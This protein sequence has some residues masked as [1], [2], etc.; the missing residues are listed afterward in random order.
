M[1][2]TINMRLFYSEA[3]AGHNPRMWMENG[4]LVEYLECPVRAYAIRDAVLASRLGTF[5]RPFEDPD[6]LIAGTHSLNKITFLRGN[7][8]E[9]L[10]TRES[11]PDLVLESDEAL[12]LSPGSYEAAR[13]A[14]SCALSGAYALVE[15][16]EV[17]V[18][19]LC[20][21]PGHHATGGKQGAIAFSIMP[22]SLHNACTTGAKSRFWT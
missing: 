22:P 11:W 8:Q 15:G 1:L 7:K 12:S 2:F 14:V 20:R 9:V 6:L 13:A 21:P 3:H 17:R 10:V 19:A 4:G 5:E 16:K 18:Y